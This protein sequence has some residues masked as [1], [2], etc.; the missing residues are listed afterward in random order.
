MRAFIKFCY[1]RMVFLVDS[2]VAKITSRNSSVQSVAIIRVDFMA[3][4]R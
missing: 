2:L 4:R 3:T 1:R